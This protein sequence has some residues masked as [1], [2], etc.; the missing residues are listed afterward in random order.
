MIELDVGQQSTPGTG[1]GAA[2][3]SDPQAASP[4]AQT[5]P[6]EASGLSVTEGAF[7]E[8]S[9]SLSGPVNPAFP[10]LQWELGAQGRVEQAATQGLDA[11]ETMTAS[12]TLSGAI[13]LDLE[14][15]QISLGVAGTLSVSGEGYDSLADLVRDGLAEYGKWE[16]ARRLAD[17]DTRQS[18]LDTLLT[19]SR[20]TILDEHDNALEIIE[21]WRSRGGNASVFFGATLAG[22]VD[23]LRREV[24]ALYADLGDPAAGDRIV[25]EVLNLDDILEAW[26]AVFST[27]DDYD[28]DQAVQAVQNSRQVFLAN[29]DRGVSQWRT[30]LSELEASLSNDDR[31]SFSASV[32]VTVGAEAGVV[33]GGDD[34]PSV[35]AEGGI[36]FEASDGDG[37]DFDHDV[38]IS[39]SATLSAS[40]GGVWGLELG[41]VD[42]GDGERSVSVTLSLGG[43]LLPEDQAD[44]V[45]NQAADVLD[46]A[47]LGLGSGEKVANKLKDHL[48]DVARDA[49]RSAVETTAEAEIELGADL[50][51]ARSGGLLGLRNEITGGEARLKTSQSQGFEMSRGPLAAEVSTGTF[52]EIR[53]RFGS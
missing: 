27:G 51:V 37:P 1:T 15:L 25:D 40:L 16:A 38:D 43:S 10:P 33:D 30:E 44:D 19:E 32:S 41:V 5:A 46:G 17:I 21:A 3:A 28:P 9:V 4:T 36:T 2:R 50:D 47:D 6:L 18:E 22:T 8:A 24:N 23:G 7:T 42:E 53:K 48:T 49:G 31:I 12:V 35:S 26:R 45:V 20:E 39:T 11:G 13:V 34:A 14:F 29:Y 52:F